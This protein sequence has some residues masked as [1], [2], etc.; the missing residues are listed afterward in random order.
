MQVRTIFY[1]NSSCHVNSRE[2]YLSRRG[3]PAGRCLLKTFSIFSSSVE[4][5]VKLATTTSFDKL[6]DGSNEES[7]EGKT[8]TRNRFTVTT[9]ETVS[10]G[11]VDNAQI[12]AGR[13]KIIKSK[14]QLK[15]GGRRR[16]WGAGKGGKSNKKKRE[17][18]L[19][20]SF[21]FFF[22]PPPL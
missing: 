7:K 21:F 4:P 3:F 18:C 5:W 10:M 2:Q 14:D 8:L 20:D 1:L 9:S 17:G 11:A 12:S 6:S 13:M 22:F 19:H 16:L 15:Y